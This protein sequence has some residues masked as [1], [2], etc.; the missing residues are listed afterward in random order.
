M[1]LFVHPLPFHIQ[2]LLYQIPLSATS[3]RNI[4]SI[5]QCNFH[6]TSVS[7]KQAYLLKSYPIDI[8]QLTAPHGSFHCK[9]PTVAIVYT[10]SER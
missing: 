4:F 7:Y 2:I 10:Q 3:K 9:H 5:L 6:Q 8:E 1:C